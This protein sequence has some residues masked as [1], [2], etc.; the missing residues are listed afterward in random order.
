[1]PIDPDP[2]GGA[3]DEAST[4]P[5]GIVVHDTRPAPPPP[6]SIA[7]LWA[8]EDYAAPSLPF[9]RWKPRAA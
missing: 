3:A 4:S 1:M 2:E 7:F 6:R 5:A 9:G 8:G